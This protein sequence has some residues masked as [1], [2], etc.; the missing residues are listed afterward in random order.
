AAAGLFLLS[1]AC[2]S[3]TKATPTA[4]TRPIP[5]D[6]APYARK[7]KYAVGY[8]TL[9][10]TGGRKVVV[11]YPAAPGDTAG[12]AQETID[13][14]SLLSPALQ[15]KVPAAD[16][17]KYKVDAFR[18]LPAATSPGKYPLMVFSHG[19]AGYPE[20]SVS[21][22]IHLASWGFV[23]AAPDHV[24]RSLD[25]LLGTA[26]AGVP[27]STDLAVLQA[28]LDLAVKASNR[29]GLL[30]GLVDPARVVTGGHSAGAGAAYQ[31]ASADPRVKAWISYSVGFGGQGG[32]AP[33]APAKPGM[34][35]LGTTDGVIPKTASEKV[36]AGMRAPKYLVEIPRAGHLVF[37]DICLIGRSKGGVIGIVKAIHLPIPAELLKLGSDGCTSD[38]PHAE[39]AFPAID[40]LTV[41]FFRSALGIDPQ[42]V[43]LTTKAVAGLGANVTVAHAG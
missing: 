30:H 25:G 39:I 4:T 40:Q 3:S 37:S 6:P 27:K 7:G 19:F 11:W 42:P 33:A 28:T 14:T 26:A 8:T 31:F 9:Q 23:V 38:H 12:H 36:Y 41:A 10:L 43:G 5:A 15:A 17:V 35:M 13:L 1:T 20:Q 24:E 32:P 16:R 29:P 34:V 18:D 21:L 22:T 2:S